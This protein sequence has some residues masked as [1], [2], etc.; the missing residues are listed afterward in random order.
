MA[1]LTGTTFNV[2]GIQG[3]VK[4]HKLFTKLLSFPN[5]NF[6]LQ[7]IH[8]CVSTNA[9]TWENQWPGRSFWS[10]SSTPQAGCAVLISPNLRN[11]VIVNSTQCDV[12]GRSVVMDFEFNG[13][14]FKLLNLYGYND[15]TQRDAFFKSLTN[16]VPNSD[17]NF[18]MTGDFNMV[19]DLD[20]DRIGGHPSPIITRWVT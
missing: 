5:T 13:E 12:G 9:K 6:C 18:I 14:T 10:G 3:A 17:A 1:S 8:Y 4:R 20:N 2:D 19:M 7:E 16:L 11:S 15:A